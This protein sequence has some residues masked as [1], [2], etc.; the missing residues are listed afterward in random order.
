MSANQPVVLVTGASS[1]IGRLRTMVGPAFE[2]VAACSKS[3]LPGRL[4]ERI[5]LRIYGIQ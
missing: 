5:V 4:F 2:R 3:V 1:G